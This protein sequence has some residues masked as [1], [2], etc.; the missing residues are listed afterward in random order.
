VWKLV[1]PFVSVHRLVL[2]FS[3]LYHFSDPP[4]HTSMTTYCSLQLHLVDSRSDEGSS[5]CW[6]V[7]KKREVV[8]SSPSPHYQVVSTGMGDCLETGKPSRYNQLQAQLGLPS[9]G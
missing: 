7:N 9:L 8:G 4:V 3:N 5:G 2:F 6:N 1:G